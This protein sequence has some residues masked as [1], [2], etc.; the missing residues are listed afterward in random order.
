MR[1]KKTAVFI[2][3]L[4]LFGTTTAI[5]AKIWYQTCA[6]GFEGKRMFNRP[7]WESMT[8][9]LAMSMSMLFHCCLRCCKTK[10]KSQNVQWLLKEYKVEE[11]WSGPPTWKL[12][13]YIMIPALLDL[14]A[15][16]LSGIGLLWVDAS[17]YQMLKGSIMV[18]S[19]ILSICC[20][21]KKLKVYHWYGVVFCVIAVVLVGTATIE[22]AH[23]SNRTNLTLQMFGVGLIILSQFIQAMQIVFEEMMLKDYRASALLIVGMEGIWGVILMSIFLTVL[24]YTPSLNEECKEQALCECHWNS[25]CSEWAKDM[26]S[27]ERSTSCQVQSLYHEDTLESLTMIKNSIDLIGLLCTY[28]FSILF[29]NISGLNVMKNLSAIHLS[30]L[31]ATRTLCIWLVDIIIYY[32]IPIEGHGE[33]WTEWSPLQLCGFGFLVLG[34]LIY[35]KVIKLPRICPWVGSKPYRTGTGVKKTGDAF[36]FPAVARYSPAH[37]QEFCGTPA[38]NDSFKNYYTSQYKRKAQ[39]F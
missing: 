10:D 2:V 13:L 24:Y 29:Y 18:F 25:T 38:S 32:L 30:I 31:Q 4:L 21:G 37:L 23:E 39:S 20:L 35:N 16:T 28:L 12:C 1:N 26:E 34:N 15:T 6:L 9:F 36:N 17:V 19:V 7:W 14:L 3:G 22:G 8:M 11:K 33:R 27:F 5:T